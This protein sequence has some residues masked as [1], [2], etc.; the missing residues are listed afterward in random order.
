MPDKDDIASA[1]AGRAG[2]AG[3]ASYFPL[4]EV[5]STLGEQ[6]TAQ[7]G[8][9]ILEIP[10]VTQDVQDYRFLQANGTFEQLTGLKDT[11]G[12]YLKELNLPT[13]TDWLAFFR[14]LQRRPD[15]IH[16]EYHDQQAGRWIYLSG[17]AVSER[18]LIE[19]A[20]ITG[21]K[22]SEEVVREWDAR[23]KGISRLYNLNEQMLKAAGLN[24]ILQEILSV[25][26]E[27]TGAGKGNI[28]LPGKDG[29]TLQIAVHQGHGD[30]FLAHFRHDSCPVTCG[31]AFLLGKRLVFADIMGEAALQGTEDLKVL[32]ADGVRAL[33]SMPL[34]SRNGELMG[35]L[36][37][38][39]PAVHRPGEKELRLLDLMGWMT[40]DLI[41]RAR[42]EE[43]LRLSEARYRQLFSS[44][45]EAFALCRV[46]ADESENP[47]DG[48]LLSV[49]PAFSRM[50]AVSPEMAEG[51]R[52]GEL[53][54]GIQLRWEEI[55]SKV[56]VGHQTASFELFSAQTGK[57][58]EGYASPDGE[59]RDGRFILVFKDVTERRRREENTRFLTEIQD[60]FARLTTVEEIMQTVGE[61]ISAF[62]RVSSSLLLDVDEEKDEL[63]LRFLS[64]TGKN[65][66]M[67]GTVPMS[68]VIAPGIA[69]ALPMNEVMVITDLDTDP[70]VNVAVYTEK[71]TR[72]LLAMPFY[73]N[74]RWK[75]AFAVADGKPRNWRPDEIDLFT[76]LANRIF[77]RLERARTEEAL[78]ASEE[79]Y[80]RLFSSID[81]G[82]NLCEL[83]VDAEDKVTDFRFLE[84]N[85]AFMRQT[86]MTDAE[87][88]TALE[89]Y[90]AMR[91][92]WLRNLDVVR[93]T[94]EP[95][96]VESHTAGYDRW[97]DLFISPVGGKGTT[98]VVSIF[99]DVT[100]RKR[101]ELA[102]RDSELHLATLFADAEVGLSEVAPD[103]RFVRVNDRL[104]R[105]F[106]RSREQL[107]QMTVT[108]V[109]FAEDLA[110]SLEVLRQVKE[111]GRPASLDK[112]YVR[113]DGSIVWANSALSLLD[114]M[115]G[116]KR[117]IVAVTTDL[118]ERMA[119]ERQKDEFIGIASHEL[120]TP[121]TSIKIYVE[122]LEE[123]LL[124][125]GDQENAALAV[126]LKGQVDRLTKLIY[127]LLDS[128]RLFEDKFTLN[129]S[130]F[131]LRKLMEE[132][133]EDLRIVSDNAITI[134][135]HD[136]STVHADRER[137]GQVLA[138]LLSNAIKYS[139]PKTEIILSAEDTGKEVEIS[140][141]D[142]GAG[143]S[144]ETRKKIFE[145]F[146]RSGDPYV[147]M[148][149]FPGMGLG[150]YIAS[151]IVRR[152]QSVINVDSEPGK[153]SRFSFRL[154][155]G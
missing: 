49:N 89:L 68:Q 66:P 117:N 115:Q 145:R 80:R 52:L 41:Q 74:G 45:E 106:G 129:P 99:N 64:R 5:M 98:K 136:I 81:E 126:K 90:P 75:S 16:F 19:V 6:G 116:K 33:Q 61:K 62:M 92:F 135:C 48:E 131:D 27:T 91:S 71:N 120:R 54:P 149:V 1:S 17:F 147:N 79:K 25:A 56:A 110:R 113:A 39:F 127:D 36:S 142:F 134:C 3:Q 82:F 121:V 146:Y 109:T 51:K 86:G 111:T 151:E 148:N 12:K 21:Q 83:V 77:P 152:H 8:F 133:V 73:R 23:F 87:G 70:R 138:S 143:I 31:A 58:F 122:L 78:R 101:A 108:E 60:D 24:N 84:V 140:V 105:L 20:D 144:S 103:G 119:L 15:P 154:P 32:L 153:G 38:H 155:Y 112:R 11:G 35:V 95:L 22:R 9:C 104:C 29:R 130:T 53:W 2:E 57:W 132:S 100:E 97:F 72:S 107:L 47:S 44:M 30:P 28:Q 94:G 14:M 93:R 137:T 150:L 125:S 4:G 128:T 10:G 13:Q 65:G 114:N 63:R 18:L 118:T 7:K 55:F 34:V 124:E 42:T 46:I 141:R 67:E 69:A 88:K 96:R 43:E 85:P 50:M 139:P 59:G 37:T 76:E 40:A 123:R 26:L 102:L